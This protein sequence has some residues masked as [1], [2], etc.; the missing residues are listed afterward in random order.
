MLLN[1]KKRLRSCRLILKCWEY[2]TL[3]KENNDKTRKGFN[4]NRKFTKTNKNFTPK[5][6]H[7]LPRSLAV[8]G[9]LQQLLLVAILILKRKLVIRKNP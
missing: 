2:S 4:L 5:K 7:R 6:F 9:A 3:K 1:N 8:V